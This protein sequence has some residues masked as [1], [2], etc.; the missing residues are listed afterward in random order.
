MDT[1][2]AEAGWS[3]DELQTLVVPV[4][5]LVGDR[6]IVKIE[7][8]ALMQATLP[9]AQVAVVPGATHMRLFHEVDVVVP[10]PAASSPSDPT[11]PTRPRLP[12]GH[13]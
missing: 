6:D 3:D 1:R 8:A 10:L 4:L 2:Y 13:G 12:G 5:V 9:D 7:H 11:R